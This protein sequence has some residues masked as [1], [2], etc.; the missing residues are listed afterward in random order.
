MPL[1]YTVRV[2]LSLPRMFGGCCAP[3]G[4]LEF[5][6]FVLVG[7]PVQPLEKDVQM[8]I[9]RRT[10]Y[11]FSSSK[12]LTSFQDS[13]VNTHTEGVGGCEG[14]REWGNSPTFEDQGLFEIRPVTLSTVP[15]RQSGT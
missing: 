9:A 8:L 10:N 13:Q 3:A 11:F 2:Q 5:H 12:T 15:P 14:E 4:P 1:G 6:I 7:T